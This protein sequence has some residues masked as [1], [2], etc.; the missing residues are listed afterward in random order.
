M[1]ATLR[2]AA[3]HVPRRSGR[4][5]Y[6]LM[7]VMVVLTI[8]AI[9]LSMCVPSYKRTLEQA[10]AD[11]AA[12]NLRAIWSAQRL[13]WLEYHTYT[14]N[15]S[16]LQSIGLLSPEITQTTNG[17]SYGMTDADETTFECTASRI[18]STYWSG[19]YS[20]DQ[21]GE[22]SGTIAASGQSAITPGFQ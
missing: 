11:I 15:L 5:G 12:A 6:T 14:D 2:N 8:V 13:Y 1:N 4:S 9:L 20:I 7:E 21:N 19:T 16:L 18:D 17:Y 10:R 3:S 22:V